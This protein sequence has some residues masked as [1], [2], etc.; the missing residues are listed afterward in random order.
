MKKKR[1]RLIEMQYANPLVPEQE[2]LDYMKGVGFQLK[3][4]DIPTVKEK[5]LYEARQNTLTIH[6]GFPLEHVMFFMMYYSKENKTVFRDRFMD[7]LDHF[8]AMGMLYCYAPEEIPP[9]VL[10]GLKEWGELYDS[11]TGESL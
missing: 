6:I 4:L 10:Q 2:I 3:A 9:K 8:V 7:L 11:L 1:L 5:G